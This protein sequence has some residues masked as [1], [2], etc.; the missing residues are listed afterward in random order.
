MLSAGYNVEK[1]IGNYVRKLVKK[2]KNVEELKQ[3]LNKYLDFNIVNS[4]HAKVK[5]EEG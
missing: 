4:H 5:L 2:Y 3:E 1:L